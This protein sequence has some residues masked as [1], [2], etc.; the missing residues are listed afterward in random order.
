MDARTPKLT[1]DEKSLI[2]AAVDGDAA[3]IRQLISAGV[4]VN[5]RNAETYPI[6]Y[7]WNTTP[8]MCAADKGHLEACRILLEAGADVSAASEKHKADGGGSAQAL[9]HAL[10]DGHVEV[11]RLLLDAGADP[12]AQGNN[13]WT[14]LVYAARSLSR[15]AVQ[16]VLERGGQP[17]LKVKRNGYEPPLHGATLTIC[18]TST[19]VNRNGKLVMEVLEKWERKEDIFEV[20]RLLL[21]AGAD[22]N[23]PGARNSRVLSW[24]ALRDEMPDDIRPPIIE[25]LLNA[26]ARND[27]ADKDGA[28]PLQWAQRSKNPRV[29]ELVGRAPDA[30]PN[31]NAAKKPPAKTASAKGKA[32][33]AKALKPSAGAS[34]FHSFIASGEPEWAL[35]AIKAPIERVSAALCTFLKSDQLTQNVPIKADAG[36]MD[37]VANAI[38]IVSVASNPWAVVFLSLF[39]ANGQSI[40]QATEAARALSGQLKTPAIFY[41]AEGT[42]DEAGILQFENGEMVA[43]EPQLVDEAEADRFFRE[44]GVYLPACYPKSKASRFWLAVEKASADRIERADLI[45]CQ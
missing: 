16:L 3:K 45:I 5:V 21:A 27:L 15:A 26:G 43:D 20:F 12:D 1:D 6:G 7:E 2:Q 25:M 8:L 41:A 19:L 37:E 11:A 32:Q 34:D 22:P 10:M 30:P 14:P 36:E 33:A 38:A 29:K 35:V 39:H 4:N 17:D 40:N 31:G 42:S 28:T 24:L 13:G 23:A 44:Q 18:N 9:H